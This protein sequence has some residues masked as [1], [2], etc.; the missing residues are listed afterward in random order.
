MDPKIK[1]LIVVLA[2]IIIL[3]GGWWV[4]N[5]QMKK[6]D[7]SKITSSSNIEECI[8][9]RIKA[10]G[11]LECERVGVS[12]KAAFHFLKFDD[13]TELR[14]LEE[15]PNCKSYD[16]KKVNVIGKFYQCKEGLDQCSGVGLA[17]IESVSL[18][19]NGK[20]TPYS[21]YSIAKKSEDELEKIE[22]GF[23]DKNGSTW[24]IE[25][26]PY[27]G[28]VFSAA[29]PNFKEVT[30]PINAE[31]SQ[32]IIS[33]FLKKNKEFFGLGEVKLE[34]DPNQKEAYVLKPHPTYK[35]LFIVGVN[36]TNGYV[37]P[38]NYKATVLLPF[39]ERDNVY[40]NKPHLEFYLHNL[41]VYPEIKALT[42][43][44]ISGEEAIKHLY[45]YE[46]EPPRDVFRPQPQNKPQKKSKFKKDKNTFKINRLAILPWPDKEKIN[47]EFRLVWQIEIDSNQES[48]VGMYTAY[49]DAVT[50]EIITL[51]QNFVI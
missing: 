12:E 1:I 35:N 17:N 50:G 41:W 30:S 19:K 6:V 20:I 14:F 47:L 36:P 37:Y 34:S 25:I 13:G 32:K 21:P 26:N 8:G 38:D 5:I 28:L 10:V 23:R 4:W 9:K 46:Y 49:V 24:I 11:I 43:P 44:K 22:Q 27:T 29:N 31:E 3:L 2:V 51:R 40:T 39:K 18:A 45:D 42:D 7:C 48:E 16:G 33:D 15:Y